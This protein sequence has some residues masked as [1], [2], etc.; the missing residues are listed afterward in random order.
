MNYQEKLRKNPIYYRNKEKY[1]EINLTKDVKTCTQENYRT[2]NKEI[3]DDTNKWK[4]IPCS[5][6]GRCNIIKMSILP[7][8]IYRFNVNPI[9][10]AME[11]FT[12]I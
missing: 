5:C 8:A 4:P 12:D 6:F 9:Q 10:I 2:L 11:Y 3:E 7:K 1:L